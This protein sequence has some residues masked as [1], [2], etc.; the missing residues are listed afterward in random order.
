MHAWLVHPTKNESHPGAG[1]AGTPISVFHLQDNRTP[2]AHT[3]PHTASHTPLHALEH[4][5]PHITAQDKWRN[6]NHAVM[7]VPVQQNLS[8]ANIPKTQ[9][10]LMLLC[11]WAQAKM[12]EAVGSC[13]M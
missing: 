2:P 12:R 1:A 6:Q 8:P 3:Y 11:C 5:Q 10:Q 7:F 13:S 4:T 9:L